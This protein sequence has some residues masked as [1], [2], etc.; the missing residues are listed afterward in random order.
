MIAE[1]VRILAGAEDANSAQ[2]GYLVVACRAL[3]DCCAE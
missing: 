3:F 1:Q 2:Q